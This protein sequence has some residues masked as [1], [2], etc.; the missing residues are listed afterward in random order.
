MTAQNEFLSE[1]RWNALHDR[2]TDMIAPG[3]MTRADLVKGHEPLLEAHKRLVEQARDFAAM[4][5]A[6]IGIMPESSREDA[7]AA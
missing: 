1:E 6:T 2:I 4:Q 7:E 3:L 5:L